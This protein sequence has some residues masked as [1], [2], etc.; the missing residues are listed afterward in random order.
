[1]SR[2]DPLAPS[3]SFPPISLSVDVA[4]DATDLVNT[5]TVTNAGVVQSSDDRTLIVP[6][7]VDFDIAV[8]H[9]GNFAQGQIGA[10]YKLSIGNRGDA[11]SNGRVTVRDTLPPGMTATDISGDGWN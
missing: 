7:G 5:A 8:N 4:S 3:A 11:T 1:C 6:L 10:E 9:T 2:S